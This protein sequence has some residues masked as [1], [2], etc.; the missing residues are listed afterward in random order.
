[1]TLLIEEGRESTRECPDCKSTQH[2]V[3]GFVN[4][5]GNAH[6]MYVGS[7]TEGH[8]HQITLVL[9]I[10]VWVEGSTPAMRHAVTIEITG[11][12]AQSDAEIVDSDGSFPGVDELATLVDRETALELPNLDDFVEASGEILRQDSRF[13]RYLREPIIVS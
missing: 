10:G 7:F 3:R 11:G 2:T 6:G 5:D 9:L 8:P 4:E 13:A 12:G 1:M